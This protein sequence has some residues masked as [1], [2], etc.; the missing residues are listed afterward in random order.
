MVKEN[1]EICGETHTLTL[2][3]LLYTNSLDY[4]VLIIIIMLVC[5]CFVLVFVDVSLQHDYEPTGLKHYD[6]RSALEQTGN[7]GFFRFKN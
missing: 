1:S 7:V 5:T 6:S 2:I 4:S 3:P